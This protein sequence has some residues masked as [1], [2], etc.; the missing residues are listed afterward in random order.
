MMDPMLLAAGAGGVVAGAFAGILIWNTILTARKRGAKDIIAAAERHATTVTG[1]AD[2]HAADIRS[3]ADRQ[4][5]VERERH[6]VAAREEA[7][8]IKEEAVREASRR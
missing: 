6:L 7:L 3:T 4:V 1:D 2:R 8:A 5:G